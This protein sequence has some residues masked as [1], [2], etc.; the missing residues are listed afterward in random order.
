MRNISFVIDGDG[1][2]LFVLVTNRSFVFFII[3]MV[4]VFVVDEFSAGVV[5]TVI[6]ILS[7]SVVISVSGSTFSSLVVDWALLKFVLD[8]FDLT[9]L[10]FS[11]HDGLD[12]LPTLRLIILIRSLIRISSL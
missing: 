9:I 3:I 7:V 6:F 2:P 4:L 12:L 8:M 1:L 10:Q 5:A 11:L